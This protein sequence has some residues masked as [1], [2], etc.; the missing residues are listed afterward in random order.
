MTFARDQLLQSADHVNAL[1]R[2]NFLRA[3]VP[4][5]SSSEAERSIGNKAVFPMSSPRIQ[6]NP[7][8]SLPFGEETKPRFRTKTVATRLTPDELAEIEASAEG[9]GPQIPPNW[10]WPS[11]V[12]CVTRS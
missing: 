8:S 1:K 10:C 12:R 3:P 9:A 6:A 2:K 5:V 4:M 11:S 7:Q